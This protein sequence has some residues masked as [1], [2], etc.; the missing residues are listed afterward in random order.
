[1]VT[2]ECAAAFLH[3]ASRTIPDLIEQGLLHS[4]T[5]PANPVLICCNSL[6]RVATGVENLNSRKP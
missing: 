6:L 1:M 2:A 5:R 3:V 4:I